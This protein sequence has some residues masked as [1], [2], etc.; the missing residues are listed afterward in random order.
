MG[1]GIDYIIS[2][3]EDCRDIKADLAKIVKYAQI[4]KNPKKV[5]YQIGVDLLLN[6]K[7]IYANIDIQV[8]AY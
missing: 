1:K 2:A 3:L 4:F 7:E 6:G 8:A 5:A